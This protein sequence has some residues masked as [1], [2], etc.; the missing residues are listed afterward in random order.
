MAIP[1]GPASLLSMQRTLALGKLAGL[2]TGLGIAMADAFYA[3]LVAWG[4]SLITGYFL[5]N[6]RWVTL[7]GGLFLILL[8]VVAFRIR[9]E[10]KSHGMSEGTIALCFFSGILI[11]LTNPV[12]LVLL[13]TGFAILGLS[14]PEMSLQRGLVLTGGV[15]TGSMLWWSCL[16]ACIRMIRQQLSPVTLER[17]NKASGLIFVLTGLIAIGKGMS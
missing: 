2:A 17:I 12:T 13:I 10:T 15:I 6:T 4:M 14:G 1:V 16:V 3:V 9:P 8:G 5:D 7:A 11:T